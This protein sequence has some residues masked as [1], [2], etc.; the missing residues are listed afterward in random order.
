MK[1]IVPVSGG[2]DSQAVLRWALAKHP[3]EELRVVHQFTG[4]DH[5]A[6]Y[7]HMEYMAERYGVKIEF[8]RHE[9]FKDIFEFIRHDKHFPHGASRGCT[10]ALKQRPF[11]FWL[12]DEGLLDAHIYMGMRAGES[13]GRKASYG[14]LTTEDKFPLGDLAAIYRVKY[15][16][17]V[18]LSLPIVDW[19]TED[20]F[21]YLR[22]AG[23]KLNPLYEDGFDRVGCFPCLLGKNKDW[24]LAAR[25]P[26]GRQHIE[27]LL[28]LQ[29]FLKS[30][31][32]NKSLMIHPTRDIKG[33]LEKG[34]AFTDKDN[35]QCGWCSI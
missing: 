8:T 5:P 26:V 30:Q 17:N 25:D 20:V 27:K 10:R 35:E 34:I 4:Y 16:N 14:E 21:K 19:S 12:R 2:K 18:T 28:D 11:K 22:A 1:Y 32:P 24:E 13:S 29:A 6:T 23:D 33:L 15:L 3:K 7:K 31:N 9:K